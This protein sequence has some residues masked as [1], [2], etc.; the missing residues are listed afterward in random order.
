MIPSSIQNIHLLSTSYQIIKKKS[1]LGGLNPFANGNILDVWNSGKDFLWKNRVWVVGGS[2]IALAL[3][4]LYYLWKHQP[5]PLQVKMETT[6]NFA[7]LSIAI[8]KEKPLPPNVTLTFCVDT[9]GSMQG[10]REDAVK[11]AVKNVLESA[12]KM[13]DKTKDANVTISIIGFDD[14]PKVITSGVKLLPASQGHD[15]NTPVEKVKQQLASINSTGG[16]KILDA[17]E[18]ATEELEK[19]ATMDQNASHTLIFLSDGGDILQ[20]ERVSSL[21]ARLAS[22]N[23]NLFAIGI[24]TGHSEQTLREI[25]PNNKIGFKGTYIDTTLGLDTIESAISKIYKQAMAT[26]QNL[27]LTSPQLGYGSWSVNNMPTIMEEGQAKCK[28]GSLSEEDTFLKVIKIHG[29]KLPASLDLSKVFFKLTY[30]DSKGNKGNFLLPWDPT[31]T[32]DP[33]ILKTAET[34]MKKTPGGAPQVNNII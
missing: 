18:K 28:L 26:Y 6:L 13:V 16:T 31:T 21:H 14:T 15:D 5:K 30:L 20:K 24:G 19:M 1:E 4:A 27:E 9:S 17:L 7:T 34:E 10:V 32:I 3:W 22:K 29:D 8:P 23:V 25:A 12:Q 11:K 33:K 2:V